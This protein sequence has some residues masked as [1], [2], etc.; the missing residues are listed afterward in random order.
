MSSSAITKSALCDSLKKLCEQKPFDKISIS[1]ITGE[2]GLNRQSFYYHFQDKYE[3]LSY[4]YLHEL[5]ADIT[6][7]VN[8]DNWYERLEG[9]LVNMLKDKC[10]YSNTLKSN[11][12]IFEH[13]PRVQPREAAL[14]RLHLQ[15]AA[16][17]ETLVHARDLKLPTC[18]GLDTLRDIHDLVR[19]EVQAQAKRRSQKGLPSELCA[20]TYRTACRIR[21]SSPS[22]WAL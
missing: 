22:I 13:Y 8:Y 6:K 5:F 12:K 11:E 4:I 3:L 15:L 2:C 9:F 17:Q 20:A 1:D 18:G 7:G 21:R 10:F 16:L 19:V 14:K